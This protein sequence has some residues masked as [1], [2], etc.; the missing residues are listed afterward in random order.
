MPQYFFQEE[1]S[2][3]HVILTV[4]MGIT[5]SVALATVSM[6]AAILFT[7]GHI[8]VTFVCPAWLISLQP[9]KK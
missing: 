8:F 5:A 1:H 9:Y 2:Q 3:V 6:A 7:C 4:V